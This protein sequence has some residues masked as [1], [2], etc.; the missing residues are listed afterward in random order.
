MRL[1]GWRRKIH[2]ANE[3]RFF[4]AFDQKEGDVREAGEAYTFQYSEQELRAIAKDGC[5]S[6]IRR[7]AVFSA[8]YIVL[9][10]FLIVSE[11]PHFL[12]GSFFGIYLTLLISY[13]KGY[14]LYKKEWAASE[15]RIPA[16]VYS[17]EIF[18]HYLI[19][20]ISRC[21]EILRT[22]K[23]YFVDIEKFQTVGKYLFWQY[24]GQNHIMRRDALASDSALLS[25]CKRTPNKVE[26]K[27]VKDRPAVI[28]DWLFVLSVLSI[29]G[30]TFV[31]S[32]LSE[33]TYVMTEHMWVFFLF[34]PIPLASFAFGF[35]LKK[36]GY[37]YKKNVIAGII[38]T[39]LLCV[40][41]SFT[42]IFSDFYSHSDEPLLEAEQILQIDIPKHRYI[43][44]Q[45][46]TKLTSTQP[47]R[48]DMDSVTNIYF[49]GDAEENRMVLVEYLLEYVK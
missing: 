31:V 40:F 49:D 19:L 13:I 24:A 22:Q 8:I 27:K 44:T 32:L 6:L 20:Q 43:Y 34:L 48:E 47:S 21:G 10:L 36:K 37:D 25:Y 45:D 9:L 30:A 35:R 12:V 17:Y 33:I 5:A 28:S 1:S 41:G 11:A 23:I 29:F 14:R 15:K 7:T 2:R 38:V 26:A 42:F 46:F 16:C 4:M 39:A 3:R 18:E